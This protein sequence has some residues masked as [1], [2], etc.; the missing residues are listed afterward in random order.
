MKIIVTTHPFGEKNNKPLQL[1]QDF[2][3]H[4][5]EIKRKYTPEEHQE[6]LKN[7][8]PD[9]IIAGT[10]TYDLKTLDLCPSLK[11]ISRVGAGLDSVDLKEC[12]KRSIVVT[13]TPNAVS[14]AVAE[15]TIAQM[16]N[17]LRNITYVHKTWNRYVGRDLEECIVGIFGCGR[18]GTKVI[19][20]LQSLKPKKI[21]VNDI[22]KIKL[23][24][25]TNCEPATKYRILTNADII[26]FHIPLVEPSLN[27]TYNNHNFIKYKDLQLLKRNAIIINT[28]RGG[29]INEKDLYK[30][31]IKN[32]QAKAVLDTFEK[33]PYHGD[34]FQLDNVFLTPHL[35]SC[36][37]KSRYNMET[38]AVKEVLHF[39]NKKPFN[40]RVI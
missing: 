37:Q 8:Q 34:F 36:T 18:I 28:S 4:V 19:D 32:K 26:T 29:I 6:I 23:Q 13:Y 30:W 24:N 1:L 7:I 12:K 35:G 38:G 15:L 5:N 2:G 16:L 33:E 10:E 39:I 25:L 27:P 9:I 14:N 20:K 17:A 21:F 3:V 31:L 40:N 11:M 22:D